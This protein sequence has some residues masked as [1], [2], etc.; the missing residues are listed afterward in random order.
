VKPELVEDPR[1]EKPELCRVTTMVGHVEFICI[2]KDHTAVYRRHG[3]GLFGIGEF[4]TN[5]PQKDRH[6]FVR[7]YPNG[8]H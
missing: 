3:K 2:R 5:N 4:I 1:L 6:Y 7:R 8:D